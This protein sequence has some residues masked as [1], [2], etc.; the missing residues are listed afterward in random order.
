MIALPIAL[1]LLPALMPTSALATTGAEAANV[2]RA[3]TVRVCDPVVP[4][5]VLPAAVRVLEMLVRFSPS[6][7]VA[8]PVLSMVKRSISWPVLLVLLLPAVVVLRIRAPPHLCVASCT[9]QHGSQL[10]SVHSAVA[11]D[12][13]PITYR[14]SPVRHAQGCCLSKAGKL[15]H[16][17]ALVKQKPKGEVRWA[18]LWGCCSEQAHSSQVTHTGAPHRSRYRPWAY[19][20]YRAYLGC[21]PL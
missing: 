20:V 12:T 16:L 9:M 21:W 1:R 10:Q 2:V 14:L 7:K 18:S 8:K 3:F 4:R 6:E 17:S 5:T 11:Y 19:S 13:Q 15:L